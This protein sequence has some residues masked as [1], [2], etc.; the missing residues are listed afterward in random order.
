MNF[1]KALI[2]PIS[3]AVIVFA[4][5][6]A[7]TPQ[8]I[9]TNTDVASNSN[10]TSVAASKKFSDKQV[11]VDFTDKVVIPTYQKFTSKTKDLKA[12]V[13][14]LAKEPSEPNLKAA[15]DA[16]TEARV[17]WEQSES[18]TIGPAKS[19]GADAAID[20][21]PLDK[22]DLDKVLKSNDK[23][24][25]E[26]IQKLQESQKG[27]HAIEFILFGAN[28][29]KA[30][31]DFTPREFEYL[32]ALATVLDGDANK[33]LTAWVKGVDD[34]APYRDS[35][36]TAGNNPIYP[37]LPDAVQEMIEGIIDSTTE[38]AE[39]KIGEPFKKKDPASIESQYALANPIND[40]R[41]NILC[42]K[43]VYF[44]GIENHKAGKSGLSA[45]VAKVN[46]NLDARVDK[47]IQAALDAIAQIPAPFST[48]IADPAAAPKIKNA[49]EAVTTVKETFEKEIKPLIVT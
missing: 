21:W 25:P 27:Y 33:L 42:V 2:K 20:T 48:A 39:K 9:K 49:I 36:A 12:A 46:P 14:I 34:R 19:L 17:Y 15:Q 10:T 4:L 38:V 45:Y 47:E 8:S 28:G 6:I 5:A 22:G 32:Q 1:L 40:F 31:A 44:G 30:I 18:F 43:N 37:S 41:N 29:K 24:T 11:V 26:S 13:D 7:C 35:F 16:W 23:L 3:L